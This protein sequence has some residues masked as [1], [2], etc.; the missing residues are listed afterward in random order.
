MRR[1]KNAAEQGVSRAVEK[2]VEREVEK[3]TQRQLEKAFGNLYG[4]PAGSPKG[5]GYDFS[6]ILASVNTDVDTESAYDFSGLAIME[7]TGTEA[8][9]KTID[10]VH[11]HYLLSS[12]SNHYGMEF[13]DKENS[14]NQERTIMIFD[15]KNNAT[16]MLLESEGERSSLAFSLDWNN[17][18]EMENTEETEQEV[19]GLN[20]YKFEKTGNT[21]NILGYTCDEYHVSGDE[22]EGSYWVSQ[23]VIEG[24]ESFWGKNSPLVTQK[25]RN[26]NQLYF[27]DLPEGNML[28]M[29]FVSKEDQSSSH[30]TFTEIDKNKSHTFSMEDYPNVMHA[31]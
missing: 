14:K 2:R 12:N 29:H 19:I 3:A 26:N 8:N 20:D 25:I 11:I 10:P 16:I 31:R 17:L 9:G 1:L 24:L 6:K 22:F 5:T 7:I 27:N 23:S 15:H 13:I 28:E 4:D 30:F 18:M 21:K